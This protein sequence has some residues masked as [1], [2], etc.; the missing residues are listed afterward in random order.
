MGNKTL[1]PSLARFYAYDDDL[2]TIREEEDGVE[3]VVQAGAS[4]NWTNTRIIR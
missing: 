2:V 1:D 4:F 3:L